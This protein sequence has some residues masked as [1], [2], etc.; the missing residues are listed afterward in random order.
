MDQLEQ[1]L[2]MIEQPLY[3]AMRAPLQIDSIIPGSP[4][5]DM[6]LKKTDKICSVNG[7]EVED[8]N[9]FQN[10]NKVAPAEFKDAK[11][12]KKGVLTVKIPAKSIIVL[13]I[14]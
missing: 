14:K 1:L 9:D 5:E 8:F 10:P 13:N 11:L 2:D 12:S 3:A 7:I 4:A 6:G